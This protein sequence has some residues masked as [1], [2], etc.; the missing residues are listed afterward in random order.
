MCIIGC[1]STK[2]EQTIKRLW[3]TYKMYHSVAC[4]NDSDGST[5]ATESTNGYLQYMV[6]MNNSE[7]AFKWDDPAGIIE[8]QIR[9]IGGLIQCYDKPII[10]DKITSKTRW[11][12]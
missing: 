3:L 4:K 1:M 11:T 9:I 7:G 5:Y 12:V 6:D 2:L 10:R 8:N